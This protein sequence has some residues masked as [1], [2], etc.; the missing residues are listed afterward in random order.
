[1]SS[2]ETCRNMRP[3]DHAGSRHAVPFKCPTR[4]GVSEIP[5]VL[6][7]TAQGAARPISQTVWMTSATMTSHEHPPRLDTTRDR[8][9]ARPDSTR[10][11]GWVMR[12]LVGRSAT[13]CRL[14]GAASTKRSTYNEKQTSQNIYLFILSLR[15]SPCPPPRARHSI[16]HSSTS[17]SVR[18]TILCTRV[19]Q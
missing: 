5:S 16:P 2:I 7:G 12:M 19:A 9:A 11:P 13:S 17:S 8:C 14:E 10:S 18:S 15:Y 3:A 6:A 1:M 4:H